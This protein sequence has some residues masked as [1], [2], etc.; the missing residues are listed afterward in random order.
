[1]D[2]RYSA[3]GGQ[4]GRP[5]YLSVNNDYLA[6]QDPND[7]RQPNQMGSMPSLDNINSA[8]NIYDMFGGSGGGSAGAPIGTAGTS[9]GTGALGEFGG[10]SA[11]AG[12]NVGAAGEVGSVSG[13]GGS[14]GGMSSLAGAATPLMWAALIGLGKGVEHKNPNTP[15]GRALLSGLGP[16]LNQIKADPKLGLTTALGVPFLNGWIRN[17]KAAK[18]KPEWGG[19]FGL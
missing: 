4:F 16:S 3:M 12:G 1:M 11:W 13:M 14:T 8:M 5:Q 6:L 10:G 2:P 18:A 19:L 15:Y 17:D 7:P 9:Y